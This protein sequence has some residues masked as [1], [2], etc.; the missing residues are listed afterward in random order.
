MEHMGHITS[1][2]R[3]KALAEGMYLYSMYLDE[4]AEGLDLTDSWQTKWEAWRRTWGDKMTKKVVLDD[5]DNML[6]AIN[7]RED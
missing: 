2:E 4:N 1:D 3:C 5:F 7:Y 6:W